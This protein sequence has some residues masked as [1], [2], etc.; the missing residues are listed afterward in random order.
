[1]KFEERSQKAKELS[2]CIKCLALHLNFVNTAQGFQFSQFFLS[3]SSMQIVAIMIHNNFDIFQFH[4]KVRQ[5]RLV[6][7]YILQ[8]LVLVLLTF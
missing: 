5:Y 2:I 4:R 3:N 6:S 1:M 7:V 8:F